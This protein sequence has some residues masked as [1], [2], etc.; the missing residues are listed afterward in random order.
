[1]FRTLLVGRD[2]SSGSDHALAEAL[3]WADAFSADLHIVHV[4]TDPP[5]SVH[6]APPLANTRRLLQVHTEDV[7]DGLGLDAG[8]M[9]LHHAIIPGSTPSAAL[10]DYARTHDVDLIVVGTH[11]RTGLRRLVLGGVATVLVEH[12][13]CAVLTVPPPPAV[14]PTRRVLV[15]V[16]FSECSREALRTARSVAARHNSVLDVVTVVEPPMWPTT[17]AA[18]G[19]FALPNASDLTDTMGRLRYFAEA[20]GGP[21]LE[22]HYHV[23]L[24]HAADGLL[25]R[26]TDSG[27]GL[28]VVG[29]HG[30]HGVRRL[31]LGS[32]AGAVTR[33]S[34]V[35]VLTIRSPEPAPAVPQRLADR[36]TAD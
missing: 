27:A 2:F 4:A 24:G 12:A 5:A 26:A 19:A 30:L 25:A 9:R 21:L 6:D 29:T 22:E 8:G 11:G 14:P 10:I 23:A 32:V 28:I 3:H 15:G 18:C 7:S 13:P 33:R 31:L 34:P 35:P 1:M 20:S 16:D 17:A 36:L